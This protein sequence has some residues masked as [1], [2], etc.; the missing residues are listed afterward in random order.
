MKC[1]E[2]AAD[3]SFMQWSCEIFQYNWNCGIFKLEQINGSCEKIL[4]YHFNVLWVN[5]SIWGTYL[6]E[7]QSQLCLTLFTCNYGNFW[8]NYVIKSCFLIYSFRCAFTQISQYM[9]ADVTVWLRNYEMKPML[10]S[11]NQLL[12]LSGTVRQFICTIMSKRTH[13][14]LNIFSIGLSYQK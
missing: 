7:S 1:V 8:A 2:G 4:L 6:L 9:A 5:S 10:V 13:N 3:L 12:N 14:Y 11:Q